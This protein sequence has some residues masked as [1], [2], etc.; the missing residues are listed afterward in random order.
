MFCIMLALITMAEIWTEVL[1]I[2]GDFLNERFQNGDKVYMKVPVGFNKYFPNAMLLLLLK[3]KYRTVQ[4]AK[5]FKRDI[6]KAFNKMKNSK[7]K[8]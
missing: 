7:S 6:R 1:D 2:Q 4:T 3:T 5:Q 8:I